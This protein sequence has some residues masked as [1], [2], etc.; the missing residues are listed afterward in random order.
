[1]DKRTLAVVAAL[2]A[3]L[4][5]FAAPRAIRFCLGGSGAYK[6]DASASVDI[7]YTEKDAAYVPLVRNMADYYLPLL[8]HDFGDSPGNRPAIVLYPDVQAFEKAVGRVEPLP[9]GAY[10]NG[11]IDILSP[12]V[13]IT[14]ARDTD[15]QAYFI[16]YGPLIHELAHYA[17]DVKL[18]DKC[19]TWL[20]EG[21]ALYYEYKYTGVEWRPDLALQADRL[22]Y[23]QLRGNFRRLDEQLAYRKAF[24][25]VKNYVNKYGEAQLQAVLS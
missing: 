3:I 1:M 7:Y 10:C 8:L 19:D 25:V 18:G 22:T 15:K 12:S 24:D 21:L 6:T 23:A 5:I 17:V 14:D 20:A 13:W 16:R 2:C 11:V 4:T 9:L